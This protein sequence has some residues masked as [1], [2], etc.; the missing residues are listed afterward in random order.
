MKLR[1]HLLSLL[2]VLAFA[3]LAA[4]SG[5]DDSGSGSTPEDT[6]FI[7]LDAT[8]GGARPVVERDTSGGEWRVERGRSPMDDSP[9][10]TLRLVSQNEIQGAVTKAQAVLTIRCLEDKTDLFVE[11]G[12]G[13]NPEP[14]LDGVFTVRVRLDDRPAE[15]QRWTLSTDKKSL[16]APRSIAL[17]RQIAVAE[18]LRF[19]F[20]PAVAETQIAEFDVRGLAARLGEVA[21]ACHWRLSA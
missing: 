11:T 12:M 18:R 21:Q 9:T 13:A 19:Q 10:V 15:R 7:D 17:A 16:F 1:P 8:S 3:A 2:V 4:G 14:G 6:S 20:T 5:E